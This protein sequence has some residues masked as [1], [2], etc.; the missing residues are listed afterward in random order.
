[1]SD[2]WI[3]LIPEDPEYVPSEFQRARARKLFEGMAP[4]A[5][6]IEIVVEDKVQFFHCGGN[7][8]RIRCPSCN[9]Q[10][11]YKW[12]G[13]QMDEDYVNNGFGLAAY[14]TPCC[15]ARHR[16]HDLIYDWPEGFGRFAIE[17]M[18]PGIGK[19]DESQQ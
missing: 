2:N 18:N 11:D 17:V 19:L 5:D 16:L 9:A 8:E 3:V 13:E 7:A 12:W 15:G 1:M 4:E 14:A 6:E 10:V